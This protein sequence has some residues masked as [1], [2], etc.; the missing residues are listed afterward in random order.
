MRCVRRQA[1]EQADSE[2]HAVNT[3]DVIAHLARRSTTW[4]PGNE[5]DAQLD[6]E[7]AQI[8]ELYRSQIAYLITELHRIGW[9]PYPTEP[10]A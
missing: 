10:N 2:T 6:L 5:P 9:T 1:D 8:L 4:A 3:D 7:A